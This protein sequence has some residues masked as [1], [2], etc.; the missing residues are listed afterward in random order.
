MSR[1]ARGGWIEIPDVVCRDLQ[2]PSRPAR[3]GWIEINMQ[4]ATDFDPAGPAPHGAGGL[5]YGKSYCYRVTIR[6][7][8]HGAGGLKSIEV[9]RK[10]GKPY[11]SRPARGGWI[12]MEG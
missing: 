5:K 4:V 12:E 7:A 1:P 10:D 11:G 2:I 3:G 8:P 6:P 9:Y